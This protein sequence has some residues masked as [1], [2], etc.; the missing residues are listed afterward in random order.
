MYEDV[1]TTHLYSIQSFR[2]SF[3]LLLC[4]NNYFGNIYCYC[5]IKQT[6][7]LISIAEK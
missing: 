7:H 1:V 2:Y 5:E 4:S 6:I 3:D